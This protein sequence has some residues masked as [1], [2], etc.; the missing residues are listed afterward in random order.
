MRAQNSDG[1]SEWSRLSTGSTAA[2]PATPTVSFGA[3]NY[4]ATEGGAAVTV[5]VVIDPVSAT[6]V[7][8]PLTVTNLGGAAASDYSG[9]PA[10]VSF[11]SGQTSN[12]FKVTASDDDV[13]D[14]GESVRI[15]FGPLPSG[16]ES[17]FP[18][19]ATIDLADNDSSN[20]SDNTEGGSRVMVSF[21]T[22]GPLEA[23]ESSE[24]PVQSVLVEV[25]LDQ[26]P[27]RRVTVP[28]TATHL[29]GASAADYEGLPASLTFGP[30]QTVKWFSLWAGNDS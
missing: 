11:P 17:G 19:T 23:A 2:T 29:G 9:I 22:S 4:T 8:I 14:D 16:V 24:E 20:R 21:A 3:L 26:E 30:R 15:G 7:T 5:T 1:T 18:A 13:D 6:L 12:D 27:E 25:R 28:I 10:S